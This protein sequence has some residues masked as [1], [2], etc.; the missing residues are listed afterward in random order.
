MNELPDLLRLREVGEHRYEVI[1]PSTQAEGRDVVYSGQI[2][3]Q[4]IMAADRGV[5]GEKDVRSLHAVFIRPGTYTKPIELD[6]DTLQNGRTW[7]SHDITAV[8]DGRLISRSIALLNTVD[9]DLV[10]HDPD[11]PTDVREPEK[12]A[13]APG[14]A[15]PGVELRPITGNHSIGGAPAE[16]VWHRFQ[17]PLKAQAANQAVLSWATCGGAI[18]LALRPHSDKVRI[19]DA[20]RTISTG[21]IAHAL[22]FLEPFDVSE[23]LLMVT[24]GTKA[25]NGRVFGEGRV[26]TRD[27]R[28]VA[29]F[30]QDSMAKRVEGQLDPTRSM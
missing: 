12:L 14:Q 5:A 8:Q 30:E 28:L 27:G 21:V 25:S 3:A 26:F 29:S 2:L 4:M 6:V 15:F 19:Q 24:A 11:M 16:L 10:R 7:A 23:W 20:H 17:R 9:E 18:G 13:A 22:H 1:Q